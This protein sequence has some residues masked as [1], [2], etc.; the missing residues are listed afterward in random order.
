MQHSRL[1]TVL[2]WFAVLTLGVGFAA[3]ASG[4]SKPRAHA[5]RAD[6]TLASQARVSMAT[7]KATALARVPGGK[8]N[9]A[10]LEREKGKLI[11]SFDV[12]VPGKPG[13]DEVNV[14]AIDG[15]VLS[16][17]HEG[18]RAERKEAKQDRADAHRD[19][20]KAA[21]ARSRH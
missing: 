4:A 11:Y 20:L 8:I 12:M 14:D 19:S 7:A 13:I 17:A 15:H 9:S 1:S 18:P 5:A 3:T 2:P 16:V 10:E 6:S 21:K